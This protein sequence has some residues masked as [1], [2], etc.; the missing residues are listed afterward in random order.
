MQITGTAE[1]MVDEVD[2]EQAQ[3]R[4]MVGRPQSTLVVDAAL[5]R[6]E[7]AAL[8]RMLLRHNHR[9]EYLKSGH[10][11]KGNWLVIFNIRP[12]NKANERIAEE[13][14]L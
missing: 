4:D 6:P 13:C 2:L 9:L 7:A 10:L 11:G 14:G 5:S 12:A 8:H 1:I 3:L